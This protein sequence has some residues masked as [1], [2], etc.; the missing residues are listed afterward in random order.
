[1]LQMHPC[2]IIPILNLVAK[3]K[4][5]TNPKNQICFSNLCNSHLMLSLQSASGWIDICFGPP[6][7]LHQKEN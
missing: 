6:H 1:M 5:P 4:L 2:K 7:F 3:Y